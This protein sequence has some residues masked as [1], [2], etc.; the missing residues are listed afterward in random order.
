MKMISSLMTTFHMKIK[1]RSDYS[2]VRSYRLKWLFT[3]T[4]QS[5]N[6]KQWRFY[7]RNAH[8]AKYNETFL[9]KQMHSSY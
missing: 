7:A 3:R 1:V 6:A 4:L 9:H 5:V 8:Y 2:H